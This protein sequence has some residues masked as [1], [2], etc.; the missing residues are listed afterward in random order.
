MA[1]KKSKTKK[2][3]S[4]QKSSGQKGGEFMDT[5]GS[6]GTKNQKKKK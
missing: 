1:G 2:P 3:K 4:A 5:G 6:M